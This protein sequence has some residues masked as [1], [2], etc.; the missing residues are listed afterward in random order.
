MCFWKNYS[1]SWMNTSMSALRLAVTHISCKAHWWVLLQ[2]TEFRIQQH[3]TCVTIV[4]VWDISL[5]LFLRQNVKF[6]AWWQSHNSSNCWVCLLC[7]YLSN[8]ETQILSGFLFIGSKNH[9]VCL[10]ISIH[11][12]RARDIQFK[13]WASWICSW[14]L[15]TSKHSVWPCNICLGAV[16][17]PREHQLAYLNT[18]LADLRS[19]NSWDEDPAHPKKVITLG[20]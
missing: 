13:S 15:N 18:T 20:P 6:N 12:L 5:F 3:Q 19:V 8:L 10:H 11:V 9:Y 4:L 2:I 17:D 16:A 1:L 14:S 7:H